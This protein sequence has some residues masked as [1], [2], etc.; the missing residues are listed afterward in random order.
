M[1]FFRAR[2]IQR[3]KELREKKIDDLMKNHDNL[4]QHVAKNAEYENKSKNVSSVN[5]FNNMYQQLPAID[6][7]GYLMPAIICRRVS[8]KL[9]SR[10]PMSH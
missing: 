5:D 9:N 10:L 2:E 1:I 7:T 8:P 3:K 6:A 4:S